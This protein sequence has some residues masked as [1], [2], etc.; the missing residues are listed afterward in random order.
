M[1]LGTIELLAETMT[2][3]EKSG[4]GMGPF[5]EFLQEFMPTPSIVNYGKRI[6]TDNFDGNNGFALQGGMK[7]AKHIRTLAENSNSPI[8]TIDTAFQN[9]CTARALRDSPYSVSKPEHEVL[10]WSALVAGPRVA[11]GLDGFDTRKHGKIEK[12]ED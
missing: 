10:D 12:E 11:A 4:V 9:M 7:D 6:A 2:L 3:A 5:Y 8:P 1:I